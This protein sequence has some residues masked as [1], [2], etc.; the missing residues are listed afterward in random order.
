MRGNNKNIKNNR[1]K[2]K[3]VVVLKRN[4]NKKIWTFKGKQDHIRKGFMKEVAFEK[5]LEELV[6]FQL[7]EME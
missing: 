7:A 6:G 3:I 2:E 4:I 1:S 5:G